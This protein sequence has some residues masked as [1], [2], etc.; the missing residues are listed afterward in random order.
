MVPHRFQSFLKRF[1]IAPTPF[2][3]SAQI[4]FVKPQ[5]RSKSEIMYFYWFYN[6]SVRKSSPGA[7]P[8]VPGARMEVFHPSASARGSC[9]FLYNLS[10]PLAPTALDRS[11]QPWS[12]FPFGQRY[13]HWYIPHRFQSFLKR[14]AITP[15]PL[16]V[17]TSVRWYPG[18]SRGWQIYYP[19]RPRITPRI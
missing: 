1:A 13:P 16:S 10:K 19:F 5:E 17:H 7:T 9:V 18:W 15:T 8:K 3:K 11:W 12:T 6:A 4:V 14:F 2:S